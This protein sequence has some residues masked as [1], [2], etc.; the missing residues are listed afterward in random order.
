[1][2]KKSFRKV[3]APGFIPM[4]M[5]NPHA[6]GIDVGDTLHAVAV[7]K[8]RDKQSVRTFGT[9]SRDLE[10]IVVWLEKCGVDTIALE[11]TGVYWKPLFNYLIRHGFDVYLVNARH[12]R[13]V[14][15]RKTDQSDAE[16]L[17]QL[18]SCGLLKSSYLPDNE[19][20]SLR[21]LVRYRRT[22]TEESSRF[23]LRMQKALELM[24]I[25]LHTVISNLMG[26]T[27]T[28]IVEAIIG[29]ERNAANFLPLID[30]RIKAD[31]QVIVKSLEGNWRQEQLF[32]LEEN[33]ACYQF[34]Q[35]RIAKCD[36]AIEAELQQYAMIQNEGEALM[37]VAER[38]NEQ[39]SV[40]KKSKNAPQFDTRS[41]L[42][43]ILGV[44]VLAI[45]GL[46][47]ISALEILAETGTDMSKWSSEKHFVS[48]LNLC[49]N[50]KISGGKLISSRLI[51]KKP[52]AASQ[53]FR[54]AANSVQRS[55]HW[56]GD[57]FRRMKAKGG[58]R[59]AIVATANKM[60]T[61]YYKMIHNQI[62]FS[63]LDINLYKQKRQQAKIAY[64]ER[65]LQQLKKEI[66]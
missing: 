46:S 61:I 57:Y 6:A 5:V 58:N 11:S 26:K 53:A 34:F 7:P 30:G 4:P 19:Q 38:G 63:P 42:A 47:E 60:A 12:V 51:K 45:Y 16:W 31:H 25:K 48:W 39:A 8:D 37:K 64:L 65:K 15:G 27:G 56:L 17:Q 59:Y 18:H 41:F 54:M 55:D 52:N 2:Q 62:A 35:E 44:D 22:L 21:T 13:N 36:K 33:Y 9:M 50:N 49:P 20:E 29:G 32:T 40:K 24:N 10:E 43:S 66:A 23:V 28:A 3:K 1:M 14:T